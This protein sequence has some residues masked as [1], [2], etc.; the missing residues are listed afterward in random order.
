MYLR[1]FVDNIMFSHNG[2]TLMKS[3]VLLTLSITTF[4]CDL[5]RALIFWLRRYPLFPGFSII[6][7]KYVDGDEVDNDRDEGTTTT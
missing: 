1:F 3:Y 6:I 2:G 5:Y 4:F 7:P